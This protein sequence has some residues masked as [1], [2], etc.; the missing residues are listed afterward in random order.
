MFKVHNIIL[1]DGVWFQQLLFSFSASCGGAEYYS[2]RVCV[3]LSS[4]TVRDYICVTT[5]PIITIFFVRVMALA[6]SFTG[7][8]VIC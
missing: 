2:E 6:R 8:I 3:C 7:S 1:T 4:A 5:R